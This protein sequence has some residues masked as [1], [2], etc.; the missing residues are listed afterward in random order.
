VPNTGW[1]A[2]SG[3]AVDNGVVC[4][5]YL[6]AAPGVYAVGDVVN[7]PHPLTGLPHRAEHWTAATEHA[8]AVAA[9]LTGQPTPYEEIGYVWSDQHGMKIQI[10]GAVQPGDEVRYLIDEPG[11]FLA[12]T[13]SAGRQHAAVGVR[14][15]GALMKQRAKVAEGAPWPPAAPSEEQ[16]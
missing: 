9:T 6:R 3:L 2:G 14:T 4:D 13:G 10:I 15:A 11:R 16:T 1:L 5:R 8:D 12:V 7:H